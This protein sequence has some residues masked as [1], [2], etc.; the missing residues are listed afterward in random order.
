MQMQSP[1][2]ILVLAG[3]AAV[4]AG[5]ASTSGAPGVAAGQYLVYRDAAGT[6]IRQFAYP[7]AELCGR[8]QP[9]AR[10]A[11]CEAAPVAAGLAARAMLRYDPPGILVEGQYS[12]LARCQADIRTLP[13]GVSVVGACAP[14]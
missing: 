13:P 1:F 14:N 10:G 11:G 2:R 9:L 8:V 6:P 4:L 5:C 3:L 12:D 7:S